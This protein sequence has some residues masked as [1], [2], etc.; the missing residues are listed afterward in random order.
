MEKIKILGVYIDNL[1]MED[2]LSEIEKKIKNK[3]K[4]YVTTLNT[5]VM[6]KIDADPY[7]KKIVDNSDL[8]LVDGQPLIWISKLNKKPVKEKISGSDLVPNL[9]KQAVKKNHTIFFIGGKAGVAEK[10]KLNL[11]KQ[12]PGISIVGTYAPPLGFENDPKELENINNIISSRH[13]DLIIA[14]FGC[15]KQEKWVY[16]NYNKYD[17]LVT[18]CAGGTVDFLSGNVKRSP[19]WV[20]DHGFEWLFRFFNEPRRLFKRYFIDDMKIFKLYFKY[21]KDN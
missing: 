4:S 8:A 3:E 7:L 9:C 6:V 15:P 21:R 20:S 13:P 17:G 19:R 11:E 5:D 1:T 18:I 12:Y 14:C 2:T 10:A 16:E